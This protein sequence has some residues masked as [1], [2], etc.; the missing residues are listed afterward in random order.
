[1]FF[2]IVIVLCIALAAAGSVMLPLRL[3][4]F[5]DTKTLGLTAAALAMFGYV[6]WTQYSW[7]DRSI[8]RL[9]NTAVVVQQ[10]EYEGVLEPWTAFFPRISRLMVMD[11]A[12]ILR[13]PDHP[14][15]A[16]ITAEL[17]EQR[18]D[19][20]FVPLMIDC[21][22]LRH[23]PV[24][25]NTEFSPGMEDGMNWIPA[26]PKTQYLFDVTCSSSS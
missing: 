7:A 16:L 14:G 1:M 22:A 23:S 13:H 15:M 18:E 11:K 8:E 26:N 24:A 17:I 6:I 10:Y 9:P 4:G 3:L 5:K 12:Q 25:P 19:T 20:I 21:V 2:E